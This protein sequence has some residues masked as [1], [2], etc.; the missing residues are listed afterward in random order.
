[1]A[2]APP[3][4]GGRHTPRRRCGNP[5]NQAG[6][7][8]G[9]VA[10]GTV[11]VS[12]RRA[13][14]PAAQQ[15]SDKYHV[16]R[17]LPP[18]GNKGGK[19]VARTEGNC[20]SPP[21]LENPLPWRQPRIRNGRRKLTQGPGTSPTGGRNRTGAGQP[22]GAIEGDEAPVRPPS[23]PAGGARHDCWMT[24]LSPHKPVEPAVF[25]VVLG[26][27]QLSCRAPPAALPVA[28]SGRFA[29]RPKW[30]IL[31][32]SE[33]ATV[34]WVVVCASKL[35]SPASPSSRGLGFSPFKAETRVRIPLGTPSLARSPSETVMR[36]FQRPAPVRGN[37]L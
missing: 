32:C 11:R 3:G 9:R 37:F 12:K 21:C 27:V 29:S 15:D 14:I 28:G 17:N 26:A 20:R 31:K 10:A 25:G 16:C 30:R 13:N 5:R 24:A 6:H 2:T 8:G 34:G 7:A 23:V 4:V 36:P 33:G 1:M 19:R 22:V 35:A 18:D